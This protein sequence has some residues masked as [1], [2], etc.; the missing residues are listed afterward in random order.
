MEKQIFVRRLKQLAVIF[1]VWTCLALIP[2]IQ[3]HAYIRS[4]GH[5]IS[6]GHALLPPLLNHWIWAILTPGVLWLSARYPIERRAWVRVVGIHILGSFAFAVLHVTLRC[7]FIQS[8][9]LF[10]TPIEHVTWLLFRNSLFANYYDDLWTYS[11]IVAASQLWNYYR[12]YRDRELRTMKL[13][14]QLAQA[15]LQ[16]L[17][18]QLNPHFLFNTLHAISSLMQEDVEAADNMVTGLSDLLRMSLE[19]VNEQEVPLK[20]EME[21]LRGYLEIQQIRF[22]DRL[23]VKMN[24]P[25]ESLDALV[26]NMILQPLVE[27]AVTYGIALRSTAGEIR[28][29]AERINGMLRLEVADSG[30]DLPFEAEELSHAGLGLAN[31]RARLRQLYGEAHEFRMEKDAGGGTVVI[32]EFPFRAAHVAGVQE[33]LDGNPSDHRR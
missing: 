19:G 24:I 31:T 6:W 18:M 7:P 20:R 11:T 13:E 22:R 23:T 30:K 16:V 17:K 32:L 12:K 5:S 3:A 2:G 10:T 21:F 1:A 27:N 26:P 14:A 8:P 15:Q 33:D 4:L 25:T 28:I 9:T 29:R